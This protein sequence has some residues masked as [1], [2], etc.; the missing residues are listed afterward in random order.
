MTGLIQELMLALRSARKAP[1]FALAAIVVLALGIG[2]NTAIFSIVNGVLLRPLPFD[3]PDRL[4]HLWHTPPPKQFPGVTQFPLSAANYLDWEQ[5]NDV[6]ERS[7]VYTFAGGFRL[8]GSGEPENLQAARVETTFFDVL[9]G[10]L[11]L[12]R[13]INESDGRP[14][15]EHVV[16][17]SHRLWQS[18]FSGDAQIVGKTIVL[19]DETWTVIGVMAPDFQKPGYAQLWTP[20]VWDPAEKAVRGEHHW[21]AVARLKPGVSV[22]QAQAR[23]D[24]IAANLAEQ[25]PA[26]DAGWGAQVERLSDTTVGEFRKPL[27]ILLG[28]VAFVLLIACAN[29]ANLILARTLDRRKEIAI[30]TALGAK[31][32]RIVR[33]LLAE[34]VALSIIGGILGLVIA[35]FGTRLVV[36]FLG[37]GLPRASEIGLD[38]PVLAFTFAIA[39]L[40]G[41]V[42]GLVPAWRMSVA[43]PQD[44][45]KQ[46]GRS[47]SG[48]TSRNTRGVLVV[49]EVA[50]S[51]V[52][53]VGA[54]LMIRTLWNLSRIDPG[55]DPQR[56]LTAT[57]GIAPTDYAD[58]QVEV[59]FVDEVLR[60]VRAIPGVQTAG[61]TDTL[62]MQGGSIQPVA[63][64]GQ[65]E[66]DMSHQPEVAV[67]MLTPGFVGAM[68]LP[69]LRGRDFTD[70]DT[71]KSLPVVV[72]SEA[73]AKQFWPNDDAIGK[74]LTLTF[75][76]G[77][78]RE[79]VGVV[80]NVK[81][82]GLD[83]SDP[84]S[85]LYW[86]LSQ[87]FMPERF[88]KF[89]SYPMQI[90]VRTVSDPVSAG[91]SLRNVL[92]EVSPN[93]PLLDVRTM[94]DV[95]ADT[96][97][98][99]RFNMF[100]L[101]AFAG[102]ALLLAGVGIYSVLAY[103]VRQRVREIGVRMA[104]G[105]RMADVLRRV[106]IDG[107]KPTLLGVVIGVAAALALTR[108]LGT[109]VFG[110]EAN[111]VATFAAVSA[112]LTAVGVLASAMPAYS[113]TQVNPLKVLRDD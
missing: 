84:V 62:P 43:D 52:L 75:F 79:V 9:R 106:V 82:R 50:L 91:A 16:V 65:A 57:L 80:G 10:Q 64:E 40:T 107:L 15:N 67:R 29:V 112:L 100:L 11:L 13:T 87:L 48:G 44:A 104:L 45:L 46:G 110:V 34:T 8:T 76:P 101:A 102:L 60:R 59:T 32:G 81:D 28:A 97:S 108:V 68:R 113:A 53:L 72:I 88:G 41:V 63:V 1:G 7:A 20:L 90:A 77:V 99:Q 23:L 94:Q 14:G 38:L 51:L 54:G 73:M 47:G 58:P 78:V 109:L 105:A 26:D 61:A 69:L 71:A 33:Q 86:P 27:L 39:V 5:R 35:H 22:E 56:V 70:A 85:T 6:F 98:P 4:V 55:F 21:T 103:S 111:D 3:Q 17:L 83:K 36:N 2:A 24:A 25:Y 31:R 92:R 19:N 37:A 49:A 12:G 96:L 93:T 66:I 74:R 30:R 95:V 42:S 89:K 18:R